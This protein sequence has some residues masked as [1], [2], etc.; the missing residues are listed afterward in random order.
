ME[1]Y[2]LK[3]FVTVAEEGHLTRAAERLHA[4]QPS[5]SG[6][7]R[8]LE[9]ELGLTLFER[10][11]KGMRLTAVGAALKLR[12]E[13]VLKAANALRFEAM[14]Q[15]GELSGELRLGLHIDPRWLK[16]SELLAAMQDDHPS[17]E[18]H[19]LQCMT[20]E[21]L[22]DLLAGRLD[23]AFVNRVPDDKSVVAHKLETLD[24]AIVGPLDWQGRLHNAG[25][26]TISALPWVWLHPLCPFYEVAETLFAS[27]GHVPI[28]AAIADQETA[29]RKLVASGVGLTLML[30]KEAHAAK[31]TLFMVQDKVGSVDL[32]F[33]YL[34]KRAEDPVIR[35]ILRAIQSL[36]GIAEQGAAT[37]DAAARPEPQVGLNLS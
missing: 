33:I 30:S 29:L 8:A 25:W 12:A 15:K 36:W 28:K 19:Y 24:L 7:I 9:D 10:T 3:T 14:R 27:K 1:L 23:A 18:L 32:S 21:A 37:I 22:G 17:V 20:W 26:R 13:A 11:P 4:S 6:H 35:A 34:K 16:I 2:Q 31:D 5:V